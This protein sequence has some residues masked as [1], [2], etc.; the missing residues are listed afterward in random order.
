MAKCAVSGK[1][2]LKGHNVSHANNRT[3]K[4]QMPNIQNKKIWVQEIGKFVR[5]PV[6]A[7]ALRTVSK[8]GVLNYA[9]EN[10]IDLSQYIV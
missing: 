1:R 10:N 4:W 3:R 2:R 7:R 8:V 6:S 9:R 5:L